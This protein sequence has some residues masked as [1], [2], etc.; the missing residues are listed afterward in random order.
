MEKHTRRFTS[1]YSLLELLVVVAL[2][3]M[4]AGLFLG[5]RRPVE[6]VRLMA[7][8]DQAE[9][10]IR[11]AGRLATAQG[12]YEVKVVQEGTKVFLVLLKTGNNVEIQRVSVPAGVSVKST[13]GSTASPPQTLIRYAYPGRLEGSPPQ[14]LG[15]CS[16]AGGCVW[17]YAGD[18]GTVRREVTRGQ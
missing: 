2:V 7:V 1:G 18:G 17:L 6:P 8:A 13:S 11:R 4:A 16:A 5:T 3:V 14:G 10:L 9:T 15:L 12:S